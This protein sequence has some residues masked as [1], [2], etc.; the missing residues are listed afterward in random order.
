MY[1]VTPAARDLW[2]QLFA[3]VAERSGVPLVSIDHAAP[4]PL[5]ALWS[6]GDL[7]LAFMCGYPFARAQSPVQAVAA[8]LPV[9]PRCGGRAVYWTDF[10]VAAD[11]PF[12][13]LA[14]TFGARI[15][16]TV[17]HSQ[18]GFNAV[19]HHLLPYRDGRCASLFRESVGPLVTPRRVVE[20]VLSRE[21]EVGPLDSYYHALLRRFD[22]ETASRL[23]T[24]ESTVPT[25]MPL[26]VASAKTDARSV[27]RLRQALV[28]CAMDTGMAGVLAGLRLTGF[29][30]PRPE[31]YRV[32]LDQA[33]EAE[34]QGYPAPG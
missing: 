8:P 33:A 20:S 4:A 25:P 1:A 14:D 16:W 21:I 19:R 22:P 6:R 2:R 27:D 24:V 17:E 29:E 18:S 3:S 23:R 11:G 9:H 34:A 15:G 28:D 7:G 10:V 5:E 31:A 12:R 13:Q 30:I 26:L 32:L